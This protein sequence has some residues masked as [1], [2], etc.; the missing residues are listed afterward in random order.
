MTTLLVLPENVFNIEVYSR[1]TWFHFELNLSKFSGF[2]WKKTCKKKKGCINYFDEQEKPWI[3]FKIFQKKNKKFKAVCAILDY[4]KPKIFF[5]GQP[6]W[7][8]F[9][10]NILT[11][12]V[13]LRPCWY[14][15][16]L[17]IWWISD[18][19][20]ITCFFNIPFYLELSQQIEVKLKNQ[21]DYLR[22]HGYSCNA[23]QTE[24]MTYP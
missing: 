9:F 19:S 13:L 6:W 10:S 21:M 11:V 5:V 3:F 14:K 20:Y 22:F 2:L 1:S 24:N 7:L 4:S 16:N 8:T 17:K 12:L 18:I 23:N 15:L